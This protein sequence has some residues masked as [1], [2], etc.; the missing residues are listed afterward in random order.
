MAKWKN[1]ALFIVPLLLLCLPSCKKAERER[2]A[3]SE[4]APNRTTP[5]TAALLTE[6]KLVKGQLAPDLS[7]GYEAGE[8]LSAV[9]GDVV[10]L[11]FFSPDVEL[12]KKQLEVLK[13]LWMRRRSM[14]F[15]IVG[16]VV[17]NNAAALNE[18]I[19]ANLLP[20]A[21]AW[22][23]RSLIA[24]MDCLPALPTTVVIDRSGRVATIAMGFRDLE[25]WEVNL[26][27]LLSAPAEAQPVADETTAVR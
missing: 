23:G 8:R 10:L 9:K 7:W 21:Y 25:T 22:A 19:Q 13:E 5:A 17:G 11:C 15:T 24:A 3:V 27:P 14:G 4:A 20:Y 6:G 16:L 12:C 1:L 26:S 18:L 2:P